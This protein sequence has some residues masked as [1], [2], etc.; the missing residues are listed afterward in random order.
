MKWLNTMLK[1]NKKK[2]QKSEVYVSPGSQHVGLT[3]D[4]EQN[5]RS[6]L[7]IFRHTA[8]F[9]AEEISIG[10]KEAVAYWLTTMTDSKEITGKIIQPFLSMNETYIS[11]MNDSTLSII[12]KEYIR[13]SQYQILDHLDQTIKEILTGNVVIL[14]SGSNKAISITIGLSQV[15]S[16][17]EPS[18][19]TIIRG[20]KDSFIESAETNLSLIR[21]R[22]KNAGLKFQKYTI[23]TETGTT[24]Y[25]AYMDGI[26]NK[27]ILAEIQKRLNKTNSNAIFDSGTLEEYIVDKTL[28]PF[29]LIYNSE[30][31]DSIAAHL[32][33]GKAAIIVDGS[34]FVLSMPAVFSD[35][36]QV[37]EDYY[38]PFMM[39]SFVRCL[40]YVAFLIALLFP[41]I[42]ISIMTYH[43]ELIPTEL[44]VSISS[45]R[46]ALPFPS[47]VEILIMEITFEILREAGI[48][49][50]RAVGPTVSI[51]GGLVIGQAAVEA[52]VI[53]SIM[54][55]IVA[56]TAISSFVSPIY[57]LS[58]STR[59]L[60]FIL[61]I[62]GTIIGL[63]GVILGLIILLA[64]MCSLR[65]FGVPFM[66]PFA[67]LILEEQDDVIIR[68][69]AWSL[70]KRPG[71]LK[72][73]SMLTQPNAYPPSPPPLD[74]EMDNQ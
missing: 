13:T 1:I 52:G 69:P 71:Y 35:F 49:M 42:F 25:L 15:R 51:V 10:G 7:E 28:T 61:I 8:D 20:P 34:P 54:V 31:P 62:L 16:I 40:R 45:Q 38:Q 26:I 33:S 39:S 9:C 50:P 58:V 14:L 63:Y 72:P 11:D 17:D 37:S 64:H 43:H 74:K 53:S 57:S 41:A 65:S 19:Q 3:D 27:E 48:R 2:P 23:G 22:I 21:R 70:K 68:F 67:P 36:F 29:P 30:R 5:K 55:I 60:R 24:V 46:E 4:L 56:I 73:E 32:I 47:V 18:T 66:A 44:L 12:C 59:L 6:L